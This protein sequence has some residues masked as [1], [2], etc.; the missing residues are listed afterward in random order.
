[1]PPTSDAGLER[2]RFR[3]ALLGLAAGDALGTTRKFEPRGTFEPVHDMLG[4]APSGS[5]QVPL[6]DRET[7]A[8]FDGFPAGPALRLRELMGR[9][10]EE[11]PSPSAGGMSPGCA[12]REG[13]ALLVSETGRDKLRGLK[14]RTHSGGP[15]ARASPN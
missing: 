12:G 14:G 1:M 13:V 7:P 9:P 3:G 15:A 6:E 11:S 4:R 5:S 10:L 2:D 8:R